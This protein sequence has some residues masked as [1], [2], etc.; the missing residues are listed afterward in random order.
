MLPSG[1][2][3]I[4]VRPIREDELPAWIEVLATAFLGRPDT[5]AIAA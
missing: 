1:A 4:D 5:A 2:M 3:T